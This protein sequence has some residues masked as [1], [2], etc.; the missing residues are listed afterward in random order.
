[1]KFYN[2]TSKT[3]QEYALSI[4]ED[5]LE[6]LL[7]L[8]GY[9]Y[10]YLDRD[11]CVD[12]LN[13]EFYDPYNEELVSPYS[14]SELEQFVEYYLCM[15]K[16]FNTTF[17]NIYG[18]YL[19]L[20]DEH[21]LWHIDNDIDFDLYNDICNEYLDKFED[22][23]G[24]RVFCC[25]RNGRRVCVDFTAE[26]LQMYD[27]LM[28]VCERLQE[29]M[30]DIINGVSPVDEAY[31]REYSDDI[32][33]AMY[34]KFDEIERL[35]SMSHIWYEPYNMKPYKNKYVVSFQIDG[36]WKHDHM[37]ADNLVKARAGDGLV[38]MWQDEVGESDSDDYVAI[39]YYEY[40]G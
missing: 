38:N 28:L 17:Q 31:G 16:L 12:I 39:H 6:I 14:E 24:V 3:I 13:D 19:Q 40:K 37:S 32:V 23:T 35:F 22:E 11:R 1:M 20:S 2:R 8:A 33:N 21:I 4:P 26:N 25:G 27:D 15:C 9:D 29:E 18:D 34:D 30:I 7:D 10:G 36:D 5:V